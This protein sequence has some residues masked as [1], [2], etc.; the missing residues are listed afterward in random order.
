MTKSLITVLMPAYN[1]EK[2]I[3]EAITSVLNQTFTDYELLIIND[4]S[5]DATQH[6]IESFT[7]T[8]I[9]LVNQTNQGVAAA[10][11][12]GLLNA[13]SELIARFDADDICHPFRLE[14][15]YN[16]LK[17]NPDYV[18]VGTDAEF[19]DMNGEFVF[20]FDN[21]SNSDEE[22]RNLS[23]R[24]CPFCH[25]TVLYKKDVIISAG[26]YDIHAH[27]FEDHLLWRKVIQAGKVYRLKEKLIK[28]RINPESITIDE[29]W[30]TKRFNEIKYE[31]IR[32]GN[33]TKTE[34]DELLDILKKQDIKKI[35]EGSYYSLLAKKYL[36]NNHQ[37]QKARMYLRKAIRINPGR[38]DIYLIMGLSFLPAKVI[39]R[40]YKL[41]LN[42]IR[43]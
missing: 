12:I 18:L 7:D 34:G 23:Y 21:L 14:K 11:N 28:Y 19:V 27:N 9:R 22:I 36:W 24:V 35:K 29:K 31:V 42:S 39:R 32:R 33:I 40:I 20:G 2:Y 3:S 6:I 30:R 10:L 5:T 38:I 43:S 41:K 1:A 37:P 26:M 17:E 25:P 4:G 16:F 15:Q 13:K 8:R